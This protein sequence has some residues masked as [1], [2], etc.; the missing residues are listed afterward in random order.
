MAA[1][2]SHVSDTLSGRLRSDTEEG[3]AVEAPD[4]PSHRTRLPRMSGATFAKWDG[5]AAVVGLLVGIVPTANSWQ[6]G[7]PV[8]DAYI[9][10]SYAL[11]LSTGHGLRLSAFGPPV[12][13]FS[14]PLWVSLLAIGHAVGLSI[15]TFAIILG[16]LLIGLIAGG[17]SALVRALYPEAPAAF[18]VLPGCLF[19]LLPA[20]SFSAVAGL[21]TLLF[22]FLLELML[23][24]WLGDMRRGDRMRP[25]T[26]ISGLL[27]AL[28]RPEG[29]LLWLILLAMSTARSRS[30]R[31]Q[32]KPALW[33]VAP[34][35][36]L[37]AMRL[38]YFGQVL[39]NSILAKS[40]LP[41]SA[42]W[43]LDRAT[44]LRFWHEYWPL[45]VIAAGVVMAA[46]LVRDWLPNARAIS[47]PVLLLG[48][49]EIAVSSGD[50]YPYERY[51]YVV[52]PV[53]LVLSS[54]GIARFVRA[55]RVQFRTSDRSTEWERSLLAVTAGTTLLV[56]AL[57]STGAVAKQ[58]EVSLQHG[59]LTVRSATFHRLGKILSPDRLSSHFGSTYH[60]QLADLLRRLPGKPLV[61]ADEV[62]I[63]S[64][65]TKARLIDLW[66]LADQH[67]S[68]LSGPPGDRP[69]PP[70]VFGQK[71][72]YLVFV[73]RGCL[74]LGLHDDLVYASS[75]EM[76]G[77]HLQAVLYDGNA[78][79]TPWNPSVP[80][81]VLFARTD[82][83]A[84]VRSLDAAIPSAYRVT[85]QMPTSV[86]QTLSAT[87]PTVP[88]GGIVDPSPALRAAGSLALGVFKGIAPGATVDV[89]LPVLTRDRCAA[90]TTV[91]NTGSATTNSMAMSL[92]GSAAVA[93]EVT[94]TNVPL[95]GVTVVSIP[96]P[97]LTGRLAL[98]VSSSPGLLAAEPRIVCQ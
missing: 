50:G 95:H 85:T 87:L 6:P 57:I 28:T 63:T 42:S 3:K 47:I 62:G 96:L 9:S 72:D 40:G 54:A 14:D 91:V 11:H 18:R 83:V 19:A 7:F 73:L 64:Y 90:Q 32:A 56:I 77:Y 35:A 80:R 38:A 44:S 52:M 58:R 24:L 53:L 4:R 68:H 93:S 70:Y 41:V 76:Q 71:P 94:T 88:P 43:R 37:L 84:F 2:H 23:V 55:R 51:M 66:G 34:A 79:A 49:F 15:P 20:T 36:A 67:I 29:A 69:D 45:I 65:Y 97:R 31:N 81:A 17:S 46:W 74:C 60:Y 78:G 27:L 59:D 10:F 39:P 61:A 22:A 75:P 86:E 13:A 92:L 26:H 25:V 30:L 16:L 48:M 8:D 5:V 12:E 82:S 89:P 98:H 33:F 1:P 21:E